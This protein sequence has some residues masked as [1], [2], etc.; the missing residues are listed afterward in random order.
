VVLAEVIA[1]SLADAAAS[2]LQAW[3]GK[4]TVAANTYAI[5]PQ[6]PQDAIFQGAI[7]GG[8]GKYGPQ[9]FAMVFPIPGYTGTTTM[10]TLHTVG[11]RVE[12][13]MAENS[14]TQGILAGA[15]T[16]EEINTVLIP[17]V[18]TMLEEMVQKDP[19]TKE[20]KMILQLLDTNKD[21]HITAAEVQGNALIQQ[22]LRPDVTIDGKPSVS[23]GLGFEAAKTKIE[24]RP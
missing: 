11:T 4:K 21:G 9:D 13:T 10:I 7:T 2:S 16:Q 5:D 12:A 24:G 14:L 8:R 3:M 15:I 1:T 20:A 17:Q 6:G 22:L 23:F 19:T 18:A